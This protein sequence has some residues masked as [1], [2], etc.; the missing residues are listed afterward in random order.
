MTRADF[1][2]VFVYY[3]RDVLRVNLTGVRNCSLLLNHNHHH[4]ASNA[5]FLSHRQQQQWHAP[6][7]VSLAPTAT[8]TVKTCVVCD[9]VV[10]LLI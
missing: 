3:A 2:I 9:V 10:V 4:L 8:Y 7:Y 1:Q 6:K 5:S